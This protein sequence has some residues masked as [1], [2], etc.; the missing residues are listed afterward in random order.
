MDGQND[1]YN[2]LISK[3]EQ[4]KSRLILNNNYNIL[5]DII[6]DSTYDDVAHI[7]LPYVYNLLLK[8]IDSMSTVYQSL[9]SDKSSINYQ[10]YEY[11]SMLTSSMLNTVHRIMRHEDVGIHMH[12]CAGMSYLLFRRKYSPEHIV[13]L[14]DLKEGRPDYFTSIDVQGH[15][16][17]IADEK[18]MCFTLPQFINFAENDDVVIF[19]RIRRSKHTFYL[20]LT[21]MGY[22][23]KG[24]IKFRD[25]L[26]ARCPY[27]IDIKDSNFDSALNER[28]RILEDRQKQ[29]T[30]DDS[31]L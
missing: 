10:R 30:I 24:T 28:Y 2:E 13:D 19:E 20:E 23:Y 22:I 6:T 16:I 4:F 26:N 21:N 17:K 25:I 12:R 8:I 9:N 11:Y 1:T 3:I 18:R 27:K 5:L 7:H 29:R 15:E 31:W 14:T